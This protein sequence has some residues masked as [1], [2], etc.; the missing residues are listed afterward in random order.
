M[1]FYRER[2]LP[3]LVDRACGTP[4]LRRWRAEVASSMSGQV[5][6]IG[7]GSGLNV[8]YYPPEVE[9]VYAVEPSAAA[10]RIAGQRISRSAVLIERVGLDGQSVPLPDDCCD[11]ALCTFTLCTIP[12]VG[13]ALAEV[14]RVLRPGGRFH[15]LEHGLSPDPS[16]AAWQHR[17]EPFQRRLADGCHLTRDPVSLVRD[18]GFVLDDVTQRYGEGPRPWSWFTRGAAVCP[19]VH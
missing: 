5:L 1:G 10:Y 17:I 3:R 15:F 7:F 13:A 11:D 18:A 8:D 2:I 14:R 12:D 19:A 16:V 4:G 9:R 6:E